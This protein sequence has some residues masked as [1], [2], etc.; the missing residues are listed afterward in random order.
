MNLSV[1]VQFV[2]T[3]DYSLYILLIRWYMIYFCLCSLQVIEIDNQWLLEVAPH[4]YKAKDLQDNSNK[5]MPKALGATKEMTR[6]E[7]S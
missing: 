1:Q 3:D 2:N 5:K 6:F 7:E 4:Y